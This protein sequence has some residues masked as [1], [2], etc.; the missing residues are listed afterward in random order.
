MPRKNDVELL[1]MAEADRIAMVGTEL[2]GPAFRRRMADA[3]G[4]GRTKFWEVMRG[5]GNFDPDIDDR[6]L[7]V[8]DAEADASAE[9]GLRIAALRRRFMRRR[10]ADA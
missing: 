4:Y 7:D 1:P 9:R 6:L 5:R 10:R 3:L 2:F 8:L